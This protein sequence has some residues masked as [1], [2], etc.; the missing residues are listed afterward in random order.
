MA[1]RHDHLPG[2]SRPQQEEGFVPA[3]GNPGPGVDLEATLPP[4]PV[5]EMLAASGATLFVLAADAD[6]VAAIRRAAGD[7]YPLVVVETWPELES[8]AAD[9]RCGIALVDAALLGRRVVE[10]IAA[11]AA[12]P[13][14]W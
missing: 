4:T 2:P 11:L 6:F 12:T 1:V 8:A 3:R 14:G 10:R 5:R 9:A 13:T 7:R